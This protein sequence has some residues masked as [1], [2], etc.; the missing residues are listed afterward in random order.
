M[1]AE[2]GKETKKIKNFIAVT[3]HTRFQINIGG[4]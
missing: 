4:H 1:K 3:S 2:L